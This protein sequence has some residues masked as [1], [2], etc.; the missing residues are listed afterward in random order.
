MRFGHVV[1]SSDIGFCRKYTEMSLYAHV[2][3]YCL[4]GETYKPIISLFLRSL[5]E[6]REKKKKKKKR[7]NNGGGKWKETGKKSVFHDPLSDVAN[8]RVVPRLQSLRTI[9][10][11]FPLLKRYII[12]YGPDSVSR[13][14][15]RT[16]K[17]IA[18]PAGE[19]GGGISFRRAIVVFRSS[20]GCRR[21]R[22]AAYLETI[23]SQP[24]N[25]IP[26]RLYDHDH[27]RD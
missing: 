8:R 24:Q 20:R 3:M 16:G 11:P 6:N 12:L 21:F 27:E 18:I 19:T 26:A 1:V 9:E 7:E 13:H 2:R 10:F 15:A 4:G 17:E 14:S 25:L 5:A 22:L 23:F